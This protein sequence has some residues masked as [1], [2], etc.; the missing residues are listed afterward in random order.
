[1]KAG[2]LAYLQGYAP[3]VCVE[4]ARKTLQ[5]HVRPTFEEVEEM[6]GNLAPPA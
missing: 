4:F 6:T 3:A 1:M 5:E 2:M